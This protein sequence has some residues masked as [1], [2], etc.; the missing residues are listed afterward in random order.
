[1][2]MEKAIYPDDF[3][4]NIK[5]INVVEYPLHFHNDI[6]FIYV[7]KGSISFQSGYCTYIL[8][9]GDIFANNG[10][11]VHGFHKTAS[12]NV[13]ATIQISNSFFTQYFPNL[14]KSCYRT[15]TTKESQPRF[16]ILKKKLL[17]LLWE[18]LQKS[19][20]YKQICIRYILDTIEYMNVNFNLFS[21]DEEIVVDFN[22]SVNN[23]S[24]N[25]VLTERMSRI[26]N[27]IYAEHSG[28]IT[29]DDLASMEHLS[30][31]YISHMIKSALGMS[32][33][34]FLC[35]A[36]VESSVIPLLST[37]KKISTIAKEVGFSATSYYQKYFKKWFGIS[38]EDHR[39]TNKP[40]VLSPDRKETSSP[41]PINDLVSVIRENLS[42]VDVDGFEL[43]KVEHRNYNITVSAGAPAIKAIN[44]ELQVIITGHDREIFGP[45][46]SAVLEQLGDKTIVFESEAPEAVPPF[47]SYGFDSI[48]GLTNLMA[49]NAKT[50]KP[51]EIRLS[52]PEKTEAYVSGQP[53]L[54]T[55]GKIPKP[56]FYGYCFIGN[57]GGD[58]IYDCNHCH[59]IRL[60]TKKPSF[61]I[62][63]YNYNNQINDL[64]THKASH[65][66][67]L[68]TINGFLDELAI[69]ITLE[70]MEG[71][72][73][74]TKYTFT[75]NNNVFDLAAKLGFPHKTTSELNLNY[76][77]Y[78]APQMDIQIENPE[79]SLNLN[80][81]IAGPGVSII[82]IEPYS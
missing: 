8:K 18:Y 52:D 81:L 17:L 67:T 3:P 74:L 60:N 13:V 28:N 65:L 31:Y 25:A 47:R 32:F 27:H 33:R 41:I 69:N 55:W 61:M 39:K 19:V 71:K 51:P 75:K 36:R 16:D 44:P 64:C 78:T 20:N 2:L 38:P 26:I 80:I 46:L 22:S 54:L 10:H 43:S 68:S 4:I 56:V 59:I 79:G 62:F 70:Q 24:E 58:L 73:L 50:G 53:G 57:A 48:A 35:F 49:R 77:H 40:L 30:P 15:Y 21:F 9:E 7:L 6:E 42:R 34:D 5:L 76:R 11:E 29:L 23:A 45:E 37:D 14:Q 12:D 63:T 72:Y 66:E 82:V 1:M